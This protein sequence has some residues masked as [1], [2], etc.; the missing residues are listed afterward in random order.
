MGGTVTIGMTREPASLN[1]LQATTTG[2]TI[3]HS[4][5]VEGLVEVDANGQYIPVLAEAF[6][7]VSAEGLVLTYMLKPDIL[8][9]NGDPFT[10][11]DVQ[12][13]LQAILAEQGDTS[14]A[15]YSNINTV[16]CVNDHT[17]VITFSQVYAPYLNLFSFIIPR[18]AG[19]L[20]TR[21]NWAYNRAPIGTGPWKVQS[22][23]AGKRITLEKNPYYR[24]TGKPYL[25]KLIIQFVPNNVDGLSK[26]VNGKL[27]VF[28]ELNEADLH[29][30]LEGSDI[31]F[32]GA[33]YGT[34]ENELIVFNLADPAVDA[35]SDPATFPHPLLADLRVR[36]AIQLAIDK[37]ALAQTLPSGSVRPSTTL[38]PAGPFAC[39]LLPGEFSIAKANDL[40]DEAGWVTGAD[41]IRTRGSL[42]LSLKITSTSGD[43]QRLQVERALVD[44]LQK[45]GVELVIENISAE[46][47]FGSWEENAIR[48]HGQFDLLL[49][50]SGPGIDPASY[51]FNNYHA[52]RLPSLENGGTGSN[53]SRYINANVDTWIEGAARSVDLA[54][55]KALY[56][57]V[58][59]QINRDL[60]RLFLYERQSLSGYHQSLQN[61]QVSPGAANFTYG[62]QDWWLSP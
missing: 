34:G 57:Q 22:W 7:T 40:L 20:E 24:E 31:A 39:P 59:A 51:I 41:G 54:Q 37:Q 16:E 12:F 4:F 45:I 35:P 9:S 5:M 8:F 36:Q 56:C 19:S 47:L 55:R 42:R 13:T 27:T 28:W 2:E 6:P 17:V 53:F 10:C 21:A 15:G 26:L 25:D 11:A 60:P 33:P 29:T 48:R 43:A 23:E 44:M 49:Y 18:S 32:A 1:P 50:T 61:F 46:A 14:P 38:L 58:A 3:L 62:S 52:S 30:L